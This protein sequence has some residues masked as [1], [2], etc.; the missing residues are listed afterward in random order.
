MAVYVGAQALSY[1]PL[2]AGFL[3]VFA[4]LGAVALARRDRRATAV[5]LAVPLLYLAYFT[6]QRVLFVRNLEVLLPFMAVA[7]GLG[8]R[9]GLALGLSRAVRLA[10]AASLLAA[11]GWNAVFLAQ[12]D[13]SIARRGSVD[14]PSAL[15]DFVASA[16][17]PVFL[18]PR[19]LQ[20]LGARADALVAAG[21][22]VT[23]PRA[24]REA[25]VLPADLAALVA[26]PGSSAADVRAN[27]PGIYEPLKE[28]P[29]EVNYSYYPTWKGDARPLRI[30]TEYYLTLAGER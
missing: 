5:V 6:L 30:A 15:A 14:L 23:D 10:G 27:W 12:A 17:E 16:G 8:V 9:G 7:F 2:I 25:L 1:A 4:V 28:G 3:S 20:A 11:L 18:A 22:A 29:W 24:A 26:R 13:R 21:N 19:V